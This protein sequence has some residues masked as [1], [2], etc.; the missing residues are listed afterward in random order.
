LQQQSA[1]AEQMRPYVLRGMGLT[2]DENGDYRYMTEDERTAGMSEMQLRQYNLTKVAQERQAKAYAGELPISP[3]LEESLT[4]QERKMTE[5]L[6]QRLGSNWMQTT[7]GQQAMGELQQRSDL[8]REEARRGEIN[9]QGGML[10]SNLGYLGNAEAQKTSY[11]S[12][13]PSRTSGLFS[14]YGQAQQPYQQQR[15][16]EFQA[17]MANAQSR[18]QRQ[19]G[20]MGGLGQLAGAGMGAYGTY[21]GLQGFGGLS[22]YAGPKLYNT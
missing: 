21:A 14:G 9:T 1:E 7:A 17:R 19:A 5:A 13:F 20:L 12:A 3:A 8:L 22:G 18:A 4:D 16:W 2:Q 10:L 6:S 11:A 15:G